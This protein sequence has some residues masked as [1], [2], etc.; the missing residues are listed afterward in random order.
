MKPDAFA[1][2]NHKKTPTISSGG[3]GGWVGEERITKI[4]YTVGENRGRSA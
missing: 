4:I 1:P 2:K 3:G